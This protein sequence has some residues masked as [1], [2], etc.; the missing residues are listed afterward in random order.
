MKRIFLIIRIAPRGVRRTNTRA[1]IF[2]ELPLTDASARH[3]GLS[4]E[5]T[6]KEKESDARTQIGKAIYPSNQENPLHPFETSV[7]VASPSGSCAKDSS[8]RA[9]A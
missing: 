7:S 8:P 5:I 1:G 4:Y 2:W 9:A 3:I 6:K